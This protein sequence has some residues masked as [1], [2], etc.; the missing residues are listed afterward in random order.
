MLA[1]DQ[2][3]IQIARLAQTFHLDPV[4]LLRDEDEFLTLIRLA[5]AQVVERDKAK[6]NEATKR[7]SKRR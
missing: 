3:V 2:Q 4:A 1:K 6:E 7:A 5:A